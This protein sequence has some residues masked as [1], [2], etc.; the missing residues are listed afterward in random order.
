LS[1]RV[2]RWWCKLFFHY[3]GQKM[4]PTRVYTRNSRTFRLSISNIINTSLDQ[5]FKS[6]RMRVRL[7]KLV[8]WLSRYSIC[9]VRTA[10]RWRYWA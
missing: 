1:W 2:Q 9:R 8:P 5:L 3:A 6:Y 10:Y 4:T 7:K